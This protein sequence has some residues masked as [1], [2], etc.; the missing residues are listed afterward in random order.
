MPYSAYL[1]N[2]WV[3]KLLQVATASLPL[4]TKFC[5]MYVTTKTMMNWCAKRLSVN[6]GVG[7]R[8]SMPMQ[9]QMMCPIANKGKQ[10]PPVKEQKAK[11]A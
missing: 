3:Q 6:A 9:L 10:T 4:S 1:S 5:F 7:S 2:A 8:D 11:Q